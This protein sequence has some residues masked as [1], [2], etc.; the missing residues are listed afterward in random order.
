MREIVKVDESNQKFN[1]L[2]EYIYHKPASELLDY[3]S[4]DGIRIESQLLQIMNSF[5]DSLPNALDNDMSKIAEI[6]AMTAFLLKHRD[7]NGETQLSDNKKSEL[8][9][10]YSLAC[11]ALKKDG[12]IEQIC[13]DLIQYLIKAS[14]HEKEIAK[15][16]KM[17]PHLQSVIPK[18]HTMPNCYFANELQQGKII[19]AGKLLLPVFGEGK[20]AP[21]LAGEIIRTSVM[22]DFQQ[23]DGVNISGNYTEYDRQ[24]QNTV[25]SL[26]LYGDKSHIF[27]PA[28]LYRAMTHM[29]DTEWVSDQQIE[30]V[31]QSIEKQRRLYAKVDASAEFEKRGITDADGNPIRFKMDDFLLS[32]TG[33]EVEAGGK[34]V[35]AY[36]INSEPLLLTYSRY[37]K[38]LLTVPSNWLD[39]KR[40]TKEGKISSRSLANTESRI[41]IKGYLNRRL[42]TMR[43]DNEVAMKNYKRYL[44]HKSK[45]PDLPEKTLANC[46]KL[47]KRILFETLFHDTGQESQD[48]RTQKANRDYALDCLKYWQAIGRIKGF[49]VIT[50]EKGK[51]LG[52]DI[53]I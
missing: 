12:D 16:A 32:L 21:R 50:G 52:I 19:D 20:N 23:G 53:K 18:K 7:L 36:L 48:R 1:K 6:F 34:I 15:F 29:V 14:Q 42:E 47:S 4:V 43:H 49:T 3:V 17:L 44:S 40:I 46:H 10:L 25:V 24:V 31:S 45:K 28:M 27:T 30:A 39:I 5:I 2:L 9:A 51:I 26:W 37:T 13:Q 33:M 41:A 22:V 38:Q 8:M 35:K 11:N